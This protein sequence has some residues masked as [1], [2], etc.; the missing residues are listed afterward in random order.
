MRLRAA[1][2]CYHC[3]QVVG[4]WGWPATVSPAWGLFQPAD[5]EGWLSIAL[6]E[7]RCVRCGGSVHLDEIEPV[8]VRAPLTVPGGPAAEPDTDVH[9]LAS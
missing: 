2:R 3:G 6:H 5:R 7:L 1:V 9:G 4:T 8:I